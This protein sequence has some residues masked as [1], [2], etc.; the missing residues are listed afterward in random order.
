MQYSDN[1]A[2]NLLLAS[3]G[4]P[5]AHTAFLRSIGDRVSRLDR[6]EPEMNQVAPGDLRDTTT[7][8]AMLADLRAVLFSDLLSSRSR[9]L[10]YS[11]LL[12]NQ[13]GSRRLRAGLPGD[14]RIGDKT[15]TGDHGSTNDVA[16]LLPPR[17]APLL[18]AA[19]LTECRAPMAERNAALASIGRL[20]TSFV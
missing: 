20:V 9:D 5:Q 3:V 8:A 10:L 18:I 6:T 12:A 19:Y 7:P 11:W 17:R 1:T 15:G 4:G 2:A 16:I 14:W 13:T